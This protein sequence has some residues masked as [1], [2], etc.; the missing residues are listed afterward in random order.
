MV[1]L[2]ELSSEHHRDLKIAPNCAIEVAKNQHIINIKAAELPKAV[3]SFPVF[4]TLHPERDDWV[5]SA[6]MCLELH[7]NLFVDDGKWNASYVPAGLQTYPFFLMQS[8]DDAKK[9]TIGIEETNPAFSTEEGEPLFEE[10]NKAGMRLSQATTLLQEELKNEVQT[11]Q[12]GRMAKEMGL[13]VPVEVVVHYEDG[14]SNALKGLHTIDEAKLQSLDSE[15]IDKLREQGYLLAMHAMLI[16]VYQLNSLIQIHNRSDAERK[17]RQVQVETQRP[18]QPAEQA[19]A[20][21]TQE[22]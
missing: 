1:A 3:T 12:F 17:I 4:F 21:E 5:L 11:F 18:E 7:N 19:Q 10:D 9:F 6:M 2:T 20:E 14:K 15:Q 16:S 13:I 8:P 22:S